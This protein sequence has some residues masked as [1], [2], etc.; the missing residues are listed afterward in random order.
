MTLARHY[1]KADNKEHGVYLLGVAADKGNLNAIWEIFDLL[2]KGN[3]AYEQAQSL[4]AVGL[5][6]LGARQADTLFDKALPRL[7]AL[8]KHLLSTASQP[9]HYINAIACFQTADD[10][11][12]KSTQASSTFFATSIL[13]KM[14]I[15]TDLANAQL[16]L[17][18]K[19]TSNKDKNFVQDLDK[20]ISYLEASYKIKQQPKTDT[21][22]GEALFELGKQLIKKEHMT[23]ELNQTAIQ[24]LQRAL[25]IKERIDQK[26]W[27][28]GRKFLCEKS[29]ILAK[30][31]LENED[32][33]PAN[34][35]LI[36]K[37][38]LISKN[39]ISTP[40][41]SYKLGLFYSN[42]IYGKKDVKKA[43]L[44]FQHALKCGNKDAQK[45]L[46]EMASALPKNPYEPH[47]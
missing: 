31:Y 5:K 28:E 12:K 14:Q 40:Y 46:D 10:L 7:L 35:K 39:S 34:A 29:Y 41:N 45:R 2:I 26:T 22:L 43:Q 8:G 13:L 20:A 33:S 6:Q 21:A 30:R 15:P 17:G 27:P 32:K 38:L 47:F 4:L 24:H 18:K 25:E 19:Y 36:E 42:D 1:L 44:C 16:E 11:A 9:E 37:Y 3:N 23:L